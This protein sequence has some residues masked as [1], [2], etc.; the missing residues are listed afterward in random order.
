MPNSKTSFGNRTIED[1]T[2]DIRAEATTQKECIT[3]YTFQ[4]MILTGALWAFA[5]KFDSGPN[6]LVFTAC[7]MVCCTLVSLVMFM[8]SRMANHK[9]HTVNRN[10]GYELHLHRLKDY[11]LKEHSEKWSAM[12]LDIGWEEAMCAARIVQATIFNSLYTDQ[13]IRL[14]RSVSYR[15]LLDL[16]W[17]RP[18]RL[19]PEHNSASY[20]ET[21]LDGKV[22]YTWYDT[23]KLIGNDY[24]YHPGS[25]L[26]NIHVILHSVGLLSVGLTWGFYSWAWHIDHPNP[27]DFLS[28]KHALSLKGGYFIFFGLFNLMFTVFF[29][30]QARRQRSFR[31]ILQSG[32]LSIQSSAVVW[33][34]VCTCHILG[35]ECAFYKNKSYMSYTRYT[36]D[37]ACEAVKNFYRIHQWLAD[38]EECHE[39]T[40]KLNQKFDELFL[41]AKEP[42]Y[43][44]FLPGRDPGKR[45]NG[46]PNLWP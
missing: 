38:L 23:H 18:Y 7:G 2:R 6:A 12:M 41:Q 5:F 33:R 14:P 43:L 19:K 4:A 25:Y 8:I 44:E 30:T 29:I 17:L 34:I 1:I 39:N 15:A 32:L 36:H 37:L 46:K 28:V 20:S 42:E 40:S 22:I 45:S 10:L 27:W 11:F 26:R 35:K 13:V 24:D 9:Y 3:R 16:H 31:Q 21:E